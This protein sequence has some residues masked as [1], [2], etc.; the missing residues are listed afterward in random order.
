M[1]KTCL[2]SEE[3][4]KPIIVREVWAHNLEYEFHLIR[5]VLPEYGEC[6][7][8][9]ID[10][11]FPGVIHTP[12]V[13]HR[14]LQPSDYYRYV[15]KPNVDDLKLIQ[16]GLTLIDDCGQLPD[17]DTDNRY[18]WQ[19][20]FCDFNVERDPHNK[21]SIDLLR[22]Q[23][24]DFNR[25]VSQGVDSFRF[26]ELMLKSGLIFK[27]SMTWVTF[28]GAY[29]FAYLVK[30]LIRRNLP[31]T[32]KEFLNILEILFG[33]NVYDMKHM[34]RYSNALYGGLDRV[35][36]TLKVDRVVGKC[37]QSGSDSLL[38]W[39]TFDKLVQT[40]FSH[41]EFEKYAGVV[42]GLEVAR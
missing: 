17:F 2:L 1:T 33:R 26:A 21:D 16:L 32:L 22:R 7:L 28:H 24:I 5:D 41:K 42:F 31:D 29:D 11:E 27:K 3:L 6:S 20:N 9:S 4:S 36:S 30:I 13:D 15:L 23:G 19:F 14:H 34:I 39:H 25:C 38:T 18:I 40:H 8:V 12:K 10:T 35:A 37:H